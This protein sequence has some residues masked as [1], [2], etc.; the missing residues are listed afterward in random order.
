[1]LQH[2][3]HGQVVFGSSSKPLISRLKK[4][5]PV[6]GFF[7]KNWQLMNNKHASILVLVVL[8][9]I[10]FLV[11]PTFS[12]MA[13]GG[14]VAVFSLFVLVLT[15]YMLLQ[16]RTWSLPKALIPLV[17]LFFV[18][19]LSLLISPWPSIGIPHLYTYAIGLIFCC[20]VV[21]LSNDSDIL[22]SLV[23][24]WFRVIG[25]IVASLCLYQYLDWI[26]Y[27]QR[28]TT[29]IPY[30]LPPGYSRV[31]GIYGQP[32]LTA[33]LLLVAIIAFFFHYL[34][35]KCTV[36]NLKRFVIDIGFLLVSVAFFL[37]GSRTG[38]VALF[39]VL[40][41]LGLLI[42]RKKI[43]L[44]RQSLLKVFLILLAGFAISQIPVS[45]EVPLEIFPRDEISI[46]GRFVFWTA[47]ILM[48]IK[49]PF[50]GVGLNQFKLLLPSYARQAH[51]LLGFVQ[52]EA[53]GYT[54]WAHN[55]YFQILAEAG[56]VGFV[57]LIIFI[58]SFVR[59]VCVEL[60]KTQPDGRKLFIF[61]MLIPFFVHGMFSWNFR[62][63]ALLFIFF[64]TL[65][66]AVTDTS[67]LKIKLNSLMKFF[68]GTLL[69]ISIVMVFLISYKEYQFVQLKKSVGEDGCENSQIFTL[70]DDS[71]LEFKILRELLPLCIEDE[72]VFKD[73]ILVERL[74]PYFSKIT[75]LQGTHNQWYNLG[76]LHR[77]LDEYDLAGS[78]L[79]KAVE[80]QPV[81]E[82]GWAT[83][84]ALNIE[85]AVRETGR[86][87]EDFLPPE[88][89]TSPDFKDLFSK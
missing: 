69:M 25:V 83:L 11:V 41:V 86:P 62:H 77:A 72:S 64:L 56:I 26:F 23:F 16:R 82:L 18:F 17:C 42:Y 6:R 19:L 43:V 49:A 87:I 4:P 1:M 8:F 75:K 28:S 84:H 67:C 71:Y 60:R 14:K 88:E 78:A 40:S 58:I 34:S 3:H 46:D 12:L 52:Y 20:V 48:F 29:L 45:L 76:L 44:L 89:K 55:E 21:N 36:D 5:L 24:I 70:M 31:T 65:G 81:F 73:R 32:N 38:L 59:I 85:K 30:L 80:R 35:E 7:F 9:C 33:L 2:H 22:N 54:D 61:L 15:V 79:R 53:M 27:G 57:F 66:I 39:V 13:Q 50:M 63:P 47:S 37:T 51:D 74:K 10:Q 68:L